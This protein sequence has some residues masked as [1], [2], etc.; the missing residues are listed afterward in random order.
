MAL[1]PAA[2]GGG[3]SSA[4][5]PPARFPRSANADVEWD[6][7]DPQA[8]VRHNYADLRADDREILRRTRDF[9]AES[10][11]SDARCVDVGS[12]ANLYPALS[13][14]PF[15]R[16]VDLCEFSASNVRWLRTQVDG[17]DDLWDPYWQVCAE[18]PAYAALTDPRGRLAQVGRVRRTSVF[19]LP[20]RA[21]GAGTMFFVACSISADR[22]EAERAIGRFLDALRPGSPFAVAVML[23]SRGYRVGR[24]AFPAVALQRAEVVASI[25]AGA[26]D[27]DVHEVL[28]RPPLRDGYLSMLL[29]TGRTR[30]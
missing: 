16:T 26:Y 18:H 23:G 12:G 11:L 5:P 29:T 3:E 13:L 14:L 25:A 30:G 4:S 21:W 7:F 27:L 2:G 19:D 1:T 24:C 8:Y 15:A 28:P 6:G 22:A 9:F 10:K 20:R 17:Y